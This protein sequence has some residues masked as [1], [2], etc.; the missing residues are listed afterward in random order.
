MKKIL[1]ALVALTMILTMI[2]SAMSAGP[3]C[4]IDESTGWDQEWNTDATIVLGGAGDSTGPSGGT[5]ALDA[6]IIHYAWVWEDEDLT[7][8]GTQVNCVPSGSKE[9]VEV[10]IVIS[11]PNGL[12][13]IEDVKAQI[14]Y[15]EDIWPW[16]GCPKFKVSAVKLCDECIEEQ[17]FF[18]KHAG[19]ITGEQYDEIIYNAID[20]PAWT[21][22]VAYF[23]MWYC[24]PAGYYDVLVW[25]VDLSLIHI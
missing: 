11:D 5:G 24:E 4:Y 20:Q 6:P 14:I 23:D 13:D 3:G 9:D 7:T 19:L 25:G 8:T 15:P 1:I 21:M 2:P 18:A 10:K 16:C 22:Y 12:D 17:A